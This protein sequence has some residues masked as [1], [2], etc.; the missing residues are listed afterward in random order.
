MT[1]PAKEFR[2]LIDP[3]GLAGEPAA[4]PEKRPAAADLAALY[5]P[6][7]V[8][9][10][11]VA[12]GGAPQLARQPPTGG[13]AFA[14]EPVS[15]HGQDHLLIVSPAHEPARCNGQSLPRLALLAVKDQLQLGDHLL[16][17]T[18]F[19]RPRLGPPPA[20]FLGRECPVC[21]LAV[22]AETRIF[23]CPHCDTPLHCE[24]EDKPKDQRL[25]CVY[26]GSECPTCRRPVVLQEGYAYLPEVTGV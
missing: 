21:R 3:L 22:V 7:G 11:T 4:R 1:E 25:E 5:V 24:G 17:V 9:Y 19:H 12:P 8:S 2:L 15:S 16:H 10:L 20:D 26:L 14:L 13:D 6:A 18:L 23:I